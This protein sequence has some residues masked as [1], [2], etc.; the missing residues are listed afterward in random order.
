MSTLS[1]ATPVPLSWIP[2]MFIVRQL[3]IFAVGLVGIEYMDYARRSIMEQLPGCHRDLN[4]MKSLLT[5]SFRVP[6]ASISC[7]SDETLQ[8]LSPT[9]QPTHENI[10][11]LLKKLNELGKGGI[12]N[13]I[14]YYS[15]HGTQ[16]ADLNR[17][18]S[19]GKDE[20]IVPCDYIER[21]LL[22]DDLIATHL[23]NGLP[24]TCSVTIIADS[25][26]SGTLLDLDTIRPAADVTSISGCL[27]NQTAASI[28]GM[29]NI[30]EWRGAMTIALEVTLKE[31]KYKI[32]L[33]QLIEGMKKILTRNSMVQIPLLS[34][35]K[36]DQLSNKMF[37][38]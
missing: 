24:A 5:N 26:H 35:S 12:K 34:Y 4:V 19:D 13:I 23:L 31:Y 18:E 33:T 32:K 30:R 20:A 17:D 8:T 28:F 27:D 3:D 10:R 9:T 38:N 22:I 21:G 37:L 1:T 14:F 16:T 6:V 15:G 36:P 29:E 2:G 7:L 25:C 11:L